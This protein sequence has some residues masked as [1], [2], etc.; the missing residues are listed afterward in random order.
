MDVLNLESLKATEKS[1]HK[2]ASYFEVLSWFHK[3]LNPKTYFEIG[4]LTG[5]TLRNVEC[6]SIAVDPQFQISAPVI[7]AKPVLHFYQKT[8]DDFFHDYDPV[9]IFSREIDLAFLDGM[10]WYEFLLRDFMNT[11]KACR[12]NSVIVLHDCIPTDLFVARREPEAMRD[13]VAHVREPSWWAGDVWK[14][15]AILKEARPDLRIYAFDAPPTGLVCITN[16]NPSSTVI[17]ENYFELVSRFRDTAKDVENYT[18]YYDN[19]VIQ[20]TKDL[21][22]PSD[23]ARLFWL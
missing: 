4:T 2:G 13:F 22:A 8:S 18:R 1:P 12:P 11:E 19:L 20:P 7:G 21:E 10:H 15:V 6:A 23:M 9:E 3:N 14:T 5:S 17:Q 16:L